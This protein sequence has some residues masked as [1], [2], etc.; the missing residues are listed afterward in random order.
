MKENDIDNATIKGFEIDLDSIFNNFVSNSVR[1]LL[2]TRLNNKTIS[3]NW[4]VDKDFIIIDFEDN[5]GGLAYEYQNKPDVIFNA[6][7][8]ST[9]DKN[10]EKIGTG[11]GL[12]IAKSIIDDYKDASITI[13]K[14][15]DGFGIR[16]IFRKI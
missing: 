15:L 10:G 4:K 5:G 7:E 11:M 8:T 13:T 6:F 12:Y 2:N 3:I 9:T 16:V 1:S 14:I